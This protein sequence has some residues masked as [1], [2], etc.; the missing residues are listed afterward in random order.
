MTRQK[1]V[2]AE[3]AQGLGFDPPNSSNGCHCS[4]SRDPETPFNPPIS[5]E[6]DLPSFAPGAK[7]SQI[8]SAVELV[9]PHCSCWQV[10]WL[11]HGDAQLE[12]NEHL[13]SCS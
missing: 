10:A 11:D 1:K 5:N 6:A 7:R 12:E 13:A 4:S 9:R 3:R 8:D 2:A